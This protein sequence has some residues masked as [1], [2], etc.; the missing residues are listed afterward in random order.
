[1][2]SRPV[3]EAE[4]FYL[5][6]GCRDRIEGSEALLDKSVLGCVAG[7]GVPVQPCVAVGDGADRLACD[8]VEEFFLTR[9][10]RNCSDGRGD[11]WLREMLRYPVALDFSVEDGEV[12]D[13]LRVE[14]EEDR[15]VKAHGQPRDATPDGELWEPPRFDLQELTAE[16]HVLG[17]VA[18]EYEFEPTVRDEAFAHVGLLRCCDDCFAV[19]AYLARESCRYADF[20]WAFA[21]ENVVSFVEHEEV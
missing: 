19:L 9:C 16:L 6:S 20:A 12:L 10:E 1:M 2:F 21:W 5:P 18:T 15:A 8:V 7:F 17:V 13:R 4:D 14:R 11:C 3:G